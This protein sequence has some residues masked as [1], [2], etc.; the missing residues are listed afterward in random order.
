V[1]RSDCKRQVLPQVFRPALW[2][3][4][5]RHLLASFILALPVGASAGAWESGSFDNDDAM[6]WV[7]MCVRSKGASA[8][9][10][11]LEASLKPAYLEAP[12]A[13]EAIAAAE[14]VAAARGKPNSKLPSTL[15]TWLQGQSQKEIASLAPTASRAVDRILN[16][17]GSELQELWKESK[18]YGVWQG[19][20]RDL[21]MRLR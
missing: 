20:M 5:R 3:L 12:E 4:N 8:V 18:S 16:A 1:S 21:L 7:A 2:Q 15:A 10:K 13:S 17:K 11:T 6:D 14:V 19:H 9:G